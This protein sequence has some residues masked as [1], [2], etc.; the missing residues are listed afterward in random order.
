LL[1]E[2]HVSRGTD[3]GTRLVAISEGF[4]NKGTCVEDEVGTFKH[5]SSSDRDKVGV[6]RASTDDF[7]VGMGGFSGR[8]ADHR[9]WAQVAAVDGKGCCPI[10]A[11]YFG[12]DE[13]SV[14]RT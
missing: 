12:N 6:A 3:N 5:L 9:S 7:D 14:V 13:F 4:G 11:F 1:F 10:L 2:V 8:T